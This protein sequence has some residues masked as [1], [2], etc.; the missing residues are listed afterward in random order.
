MDKNSNYKV[1]TE[2]ELFNLNEQLIEYNVIADFSSDPHN[3]DQ[4]DI[5]G[6]LNGDYIKTVKFN[7]SNVQA[8]INTLATLT[9]D[10]KKELSIAV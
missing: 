8:I 3:Q 9:Q 1:P 6:F 10:A 5:W 2:N 4:I 7:Q